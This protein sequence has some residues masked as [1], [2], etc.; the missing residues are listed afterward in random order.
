MCK[1]ETSF[2]AKA[3]FPRIFCLLCAVSLTIWVSVSAPAYA[4]NV[5]C[6]VRLVFDTSPNG[7][8]L[9]TYRL[10]MQIKNTTPQ[11]L[12]AVSAHWLDET[13]Q[14]IGNSDADCRF[15]GMALGLSQ[16]GQCTAQIQ[17]VNQRWM[18]KLGQMIWTE[19]VNSE[20]T[21]FK[22]IKSCKIV[23]YRFE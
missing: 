13:G 20:L 7:H 9:V 6:Q 4:Q 16:T 1:F 5:P 14:N 21:E 3:F 19:M 23:G 12:I 22:R 11:P 17:A 18:E 10:F 15:D 8:Q 2:K